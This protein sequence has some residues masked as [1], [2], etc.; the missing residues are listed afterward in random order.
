MQCPGDPCAMRGQHR[1]PSPTR[2]SFATFAQQIQTVGPQAY[3]QMKAHR[4]GEDVYDPA[5]K[6]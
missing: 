4:D 6:E 5:A 3:L 2:D 1:H